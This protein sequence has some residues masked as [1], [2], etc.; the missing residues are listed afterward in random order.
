VYSFEPSPSTYSYL[1]KNI[2]SG[3]LERVTPVNVGLGKEAGT[4]ELTFAKNNRSGGFVSNLM[5]ASDGHE[6]EQIR[7]MKGDD[8][9][10]EHAIS[11]LD[12]IFFAFGLRKGY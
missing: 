1:E 10:G 5:S 8:F 3:R 7:I 4:F 9:I 6:V 2:R 11:K 12:F